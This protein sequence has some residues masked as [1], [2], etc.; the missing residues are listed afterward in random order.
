VSDLSTQ[1]IKGIQ[2]IYG[3]P[4][5]TVAEQP[6]PAAPVAPPQN[7]HP[8]GLVS[9]LTPAEIKAH[10]DTL[11]AEADILNLTASVSDQLSIH[12]ES[13]IVNK[14]IKDDDR[15]FDIFESKVCNTVST[16]SSA[17]GKNKLSAAANSASERSKKAA[18]SLNE[19]VHALDHLTTLTG[20]Q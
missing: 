17:D 11:R 3:K 9:K 7:G 14:A 5:A 15:C 13:A 1:D 20:G 2:H 16:P 10:G 18:N 12:V 19:L 4:I 8:D 6:S